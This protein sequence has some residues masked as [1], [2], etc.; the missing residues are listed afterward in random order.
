VNF[1]VSATSEV[2][3]D[4]RNFFVAGRTTLYGF[5]VFAE[6]GQEPA[7][8]RAAQAREPRRRRPA[9][10]AHQAFERPW[11]EIAQVAQD[12]IA[13]AIRARRCS[14]WTSGQ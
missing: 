4:V 1:G 5:Y 13:R 8:P 7:G 2:T 10:A 14:R 11:K 9:D 6:L 12:L 3:F